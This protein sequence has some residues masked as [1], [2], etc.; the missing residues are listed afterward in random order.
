VTADTKS[1]CQKIDLANFLSPLSSVVISFNC[2][3]E[4]N[5]LRDFGRNAI[6]N[7]HNWN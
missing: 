1:G 5:I 4:E 3:L 7:F 2:Q 6:L